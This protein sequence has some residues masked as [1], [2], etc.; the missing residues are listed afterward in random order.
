MSSRPSQFALTSSGPGR[1][2]STTELLA[3]PPPEWL[4]EPIMPERGMVGL[5]GVA[6]SG[7]SFLAIDFAM[8]VAT[9]RPWQGRPTQ[10][11]FVLYISAEGGAGIGK[12]VKAWLKANNVDAK[13]ADIAWMVEPIEVTA[14]SEQVEALFDRIINEI[15]RYPMLV[16]ID[17]LARC[18]NG[19]ENK[20]E[21]M[22]AFVAGVDKMRHSLGCTVII[23][24]HTRL[25][26]DRER[27][28]TV[29]RGAADT[30]LA[31]AQTGH[32]QFSVTCTKQKDAEAFEELA[33][34][35]SKI[36][37]TDSCVLASTQLAT[38][39]RIEHANQLLTLLEI[40]GPLTWDA[41]MSASGLTPSQFSKAFG[42]LKKESRVVKNEDHCWVET[43]TQK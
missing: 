13:D 36:E 33:F 8:A 32:L 20:Q 37:G 23:V 40:H 3:F 31:V 2:Y 30:M 16:I 7:K 19:D 9:G 18:F 22:N 5:Y 25:G 34:K 38:A 6:G 15:E 17:T 26:D 21:D 28:S 10:K 43:K 27:G 41:W 4:I 29:F 14:D 11:G 39:V 35:L 42:L 1:L 12:R 24:H